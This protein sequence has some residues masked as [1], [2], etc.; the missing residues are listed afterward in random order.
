LNDMM[1][2]LFSTVLF[3]CNSIPTVSKASCDRAS[4][5]VATAQREA[6]QRVQAEQLKLE[7][8]HD[9]MK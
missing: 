5:S 1:C 3:P 7:K 9:I 8:A 4:K 2:L 6:G